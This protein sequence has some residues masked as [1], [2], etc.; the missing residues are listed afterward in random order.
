MDTYRWTWLST[1]GASLPA[2]TVIHKQS[3]WDR[4][5][6]LRDRALVKSGLVT[7][8]QQASFQAA[9]A[10]HSG[11]WLHV[12]PIASCG[13]RLDDESIHVAVG[14]RLGT[15]VC[16]PHVCGCGT[17]VDARGSHAFICKRAHGR[18][19]RHQAL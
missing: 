9:V 4:P 11:D 5:S 14:L 17:Q 7:C 12:L 2:D 18:I 10:P 1:F 15:D 19:A 6:V 16:V 13:L 3:H 8:E